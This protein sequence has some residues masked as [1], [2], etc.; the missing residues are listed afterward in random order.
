MLAVEQLLSQMVSGREFIKGE[1]SAMSDILLRSL[2]ADDIAGLFVFHAD[3]QAAWQAGGGSGPE[4][5]P[6]FTLR[7]ENLMAADPEDAAVQVI[8]E[9]GTLCGYIGY[10][11]RNSPDR[12]VCYWIGAEFSGRGI[13]TAALRRLLPEMATKFPG[14]PLLARVVHGNDASVRVLEKCG[15]VAIGEETFFSKIRGEEVEETLYQWEPADTHT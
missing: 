11:K 15:F 8:E 13:A 4:D 7:M 3:K 10:F 2:A 1:R 12:E 6:A 9:D 5:E 14:Q